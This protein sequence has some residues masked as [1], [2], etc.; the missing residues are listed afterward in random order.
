MNIEDY[1][2]HD[3]RLLRVTENTNDHSLE[4]LLDF[5]TDWSNNI[6][7]HRV[8]KFTEVIFYNIDELPFLGP[9][10]I[11]S[12]INHGQI[13]KTFGADRNQI[14]AVRTRIEIQTNAG[15]RIVEYEDCSFVNSKK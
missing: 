4:F 15:N 11:L 7:E 8:L 2:F 13:T 12:I 6:F 1:S 9:P 5:P 3:A 10:T 14:T